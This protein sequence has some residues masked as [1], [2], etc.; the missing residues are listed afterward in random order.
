MLDFDRLDFCV[1]G[2]GFAPVLSKE[3]SSI[4]MDSFST[5]SVLYADKGTVRFQVSL[6]FFIV[7]EAP[8]ASNITR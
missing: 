7:H 3:C 1:L 2:S 8:F 6:L 4:S 5:F